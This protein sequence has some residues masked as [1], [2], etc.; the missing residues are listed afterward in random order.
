MKDSPI[1]V[2]DSG[3]GGL[4]VLHE[5]RQILPSEH[6]IY[7]GDR[8]NAPYG[9]KTSQEVEKL[10]IQA[11]ST[12]LCYNPKALVLACNSA[13]AVVVDHLRETFD[14][15]VIGMEPAIKPAIEIS[16]NQKVL[17]LA[18]EITLNEDK[19]H[20]LI[21]RLHAKDR[22]ISMAMP[23]LVRF[24]EQSV[25]DDQRIHHFLS[26]KFCEINWSEFSSVVL[27]CTHYEYFKKCLS[28][29]L[30]SSVHIFSGTGGTVKRLLTRIEIG[31]EE[32]EG[33]LLVLD[34]GK[35]VPNEAISVFLAQLEKGASTL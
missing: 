16:D 1:I 15:P 30:P 27:G 24:A 18:T 20:K 32:S 19:L 6:F 12:L 21:D 2:F 14:F 28:T 25:F 4:T 11:I 7:Y 9:E 8:A 22:V 31:G 34:S 29:F 17:L 3:I 23:E 33:S 10:T 13:T 35:Q 26:E 5:A